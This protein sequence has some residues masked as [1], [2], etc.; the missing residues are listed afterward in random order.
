MHVTTC[1]FQ[2][3]GY[4]YIQLAYCDIYYRL[5]TIQHATFMQGNMIIF[6]FKCTFTSCSSYI[7]IYINESCAVSSE[8]ECTAITEQLYHQDMHLLQHNSVHRYYWQAGA[9]Q[10]CRATCA[11]F[12]YIIY[13]WAL[14]HTV[15]FYMPSNFTCACPSFPIS[16]AIG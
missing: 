16:H 14:S 15:M 9:S 10:P 11:I 6:P 8:G 5:T 2:G 3:A 7:Y 4:Y 1:T 12:P 13:I